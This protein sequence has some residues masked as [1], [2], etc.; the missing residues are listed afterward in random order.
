MPSLR[1]SRFLLALLIPFSIALSAATGFGEV[2]TERLAELKATISSS[3]AN[4]KALLTS[5]TAEH[6]KLLSLSDAIRTES[7]TYSIMISTHRNLLLLPGTTVADLES[8]RAD[9][10]AAFRA[11]T[12]QLGDLEKGVTRIEKIRTRTGEQLRTTLA[13]QAALDASPASSAESPLKQQIPRLV[14]LLEAKASVL[15]NLRTLYETRNLAFSQLHRDLS[16]LIPEYQKTIQERKTRELF[17]K[18]NGIREILDPAAPY[19]IFFQMKAGFSRFLTPRFWKQE[20]APLAT[21]PSA[22]VF[23]IFFAGIVLGIISWK[24]RRTI[25]CNLLNPVQQEGWHG[26]LLELIHR[27]SPFVILSTALEMALR[28]LPALSAIPVLHTAGQILW[29]FTVSFGMKI[30]LTACN[31]DGRPA[32]PSSFTTISRHG[33]RM[34][35]AFGPVFVLTSWIFPPESTLLLL[36]RIIFETLLVVRILRFWHHYDREIADTHHALPHA[37]ALRIL[38]QTIVVGGPVLEVAGYGSLALFW[39]R[40]W[41]LTLLVCGLYVLLV[42]A[43]REWRSIAAPA[44]TDEKGD[45][46]TLAPRSRP[47]YRLFLR[48]LPVPVALLLAIGLASAWGIRQDLIPQVLRIIRHPVHLGSMEFSIIRILEAAVIIVLTAVFTRAIRGF[49]ERNLLSET[50]IQEGLRASIVTIFGYLIWGMGILFALHVFGLNTTSLTVAF[51]AIGVGLGFGLQTI[52]NNF[53]SGIILLFE[54]PIQV[55]DTIEIDGIWATVTKI[56]FRS[57][58]VQTFDN[59]SLI[60]PNADFISTRVVNWS[61]KDQRVRRNVMVGVSYDADPE[62]VQKLLHEIVTDIKGILAYPYPDIH[63]MAFGDSSL[64]FR[65]RYWSTL[66]WFREAETRLLSAIHREF[67]NHGIEIP[68]PQRDVHIRSDRRENIAEGALPPS[69]MDPACGPMENRHRNRSDF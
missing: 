49:L 29:I 38:T 10:Q 51:G 26:V 55:G 7:S 66:D 58:V 34:L 22:L 39:Y 8:A 67:R 50:D 53:V 19:E 46:D 61:F 21:L 44:V 69:Q 18:G 24:L 3:L 64:D 52:F 35:L 36:F 14:S 12:D 33:T 15:E 60:I 65:V 9:Q 30:F 1:Q 2:H 45:P 5:L 11:V 20:T 54:R 40:S 16:A 41:G 48:L 4:E 31:Q 63:F 32:L 42:A 59:A 47:L 56:N 43:T 13:Q 28:L 25:G 57:T 37:P 23:R 27:I 68:Y 17:R 62:A 6:Q